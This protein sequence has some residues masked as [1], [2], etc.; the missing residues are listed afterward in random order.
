MLEEY[1]AGGALAERIQDNLLS[2]DGARDIGLRLIGAI[3]H[4]TSRELVHHD[5]KPANIMFR[6]VWSDPVV[7]VVISMC[8][9]GMHPHECAGDSD[10]D[11]VNR[12]ATRERPGAAF[13]T[14]SRVIGLPV[15]A[16]ATQG[17]ARA[18]GSLCNCCLFH[19]MSIAAKLV[20]GHAVKVVLENK[21]R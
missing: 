17:A 1:M 16:L 13:L 9:L 6:R 15:L 3:E 14:Q 8:T 5:L 4:M 2:P 19:A 11:V 21:Y 20:D 12:V 7:G 10:S 18:I